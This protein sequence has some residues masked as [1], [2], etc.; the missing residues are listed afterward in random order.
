MRN[1]FI[2]VGRDVWENGVMGS[3]GEI[4]IKQVDGRRCELDFGKR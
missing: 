2:L 4:S 3:I 1:R